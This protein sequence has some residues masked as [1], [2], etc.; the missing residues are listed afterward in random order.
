MTKDPEMNQPG[1]KGIRRRK[2]KVR[3]E[4]EGEGDAEADNEVSHLVHCPGVSRLM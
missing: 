2:K 1:Q 3:A 4:A